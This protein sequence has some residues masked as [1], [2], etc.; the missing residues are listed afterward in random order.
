[1]VV[2]PEG[3]LPDGKTRI[4]ALNHSKYNDVK[5]MVYST[6]KNDSVL[7]DYRVVPITRNTDNYANST[8][9]FGYLPSDS[10]TGKQSFCDPDARYS[11]TS[12]YISPS[13]YLN[14]AMN[15]EYY[16]EITGGNALSDFNGLSNTRQLCNLGNE[17]VAANTAYNIDEY[18]LE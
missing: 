6:V 10:F 13:P 3:M 8:N 14:G 15:P 11:T 1:V 4:V 18:G 2:I 9:Y 17:Y 5:Y 16:K 7:A 12:S